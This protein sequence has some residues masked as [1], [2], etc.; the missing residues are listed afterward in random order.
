M[1]WDRSLL[2]NLSRVSFYA[3]LPCVSMLDVN[4]Q[5]NLEAVQPESGTSRLVPQ[6]EGKSKQ[7]S[8]DSF[9]RFLIDWRHGCCRKEP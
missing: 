2:S 6:R 5:I 8:R 1:D 3:K 4:R 7:S 9:I